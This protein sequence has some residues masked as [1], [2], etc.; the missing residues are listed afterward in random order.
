MRS[1]LQKL[2]ESKITKKV[3]LTSIILICLACELK[4]PT[5]NQYLNSLENSS[6]LQH[7]KSLLDAAIFIARVCQLHDIDQKYRCLFLG[8]RCGEE[9]CSH[10]LFGWMGSNS[11]MQFIIIDFTLSILSF[12]SWFSS[13]NLYWILP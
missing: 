9:K 6:W 5:M 1:S 13:K 4:N 3:E 12:Y 10:S 8:N 11:S 2:L 7:I